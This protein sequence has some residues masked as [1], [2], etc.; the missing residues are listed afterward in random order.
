VTVPAKTRSGGLEV[1]LVHG[2]HDAWPVIEAILRRLGH[3][4]RTIGAA[5]DPDIVINVAESNGAIPVVQELRERRRPV[6]AFLVDTTERA[7]TSAAYAGVVMH[8]LGRDPAAWPKVVEVALRPY[9][10]VHELEGA[11]QRR[12]VIERAKGV[13][14][15]RRSIREREAFE[16]LRREARATNRR[17][18]DVAAA[19]LEG[20]LPLA[21]RAEQG[22][23]AELMH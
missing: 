9:T 15:E 13:L 1:L 19:I 22:A 6:I 5:H 17:V 7:V 8:V 3:D 21:P 4:V 16:L 14:M 10:T 20:H 11:L 12:A 2:D 18:V 23:A